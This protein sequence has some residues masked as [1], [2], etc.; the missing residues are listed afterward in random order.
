MELASQLYAGTCR[1]LELVAEFDRRAGFGDW[2]A[3]STA[4]WLS[5]R[6][7]ISPRAARALL[8]AER[9]ALVETGREPPLMLLDDVM[10]ELDPERRR[11]L[12]HRLQAGGGQAV[13]TA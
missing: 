2:G 8:F 11:R 7:A 10:S 6:C 4:E 1:W 12:G 13:I 3:R 5:W 9:E